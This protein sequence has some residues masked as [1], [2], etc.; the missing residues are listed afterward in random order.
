MKRTPG[1][2]KW[3]DNS[4]QKNY[5]PQVNRKSI[6][7]TQTSFP[8]VMSGVDAMKAKYRQTRHSSI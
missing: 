5:T 1:I 4:F 8:S 7:S 2:N 6:E 3:Q